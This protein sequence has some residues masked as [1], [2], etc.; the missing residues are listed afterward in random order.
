MPLKISAG[1]ERRTERGI[2]IGSIN[3]SD[4]ELRMAMQP[5]ELVHWRDWIPWRKIKNVVGWGN[6]GRLHDSNKETKTAG[7]VRVKFLVHGCM[8]E[9]ATPRHDYPVGELRESTG[10]GAF[11][12]WKPCRDALCLAASTPPWRPNRGQ[13]PLQGSASQ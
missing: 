9:G 10:Q 3:I 1:R 7:T 11:F 5:N 8:M 6:S 4:L 13:L 2:N 12:F